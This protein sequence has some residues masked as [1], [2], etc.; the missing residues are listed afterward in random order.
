MSTGIEFEEDKSSY[1]GQPRVASP[2]GMGGGSVPTGNE[3]GIVGWL[4][5]SGL[6]KSAN[7]AQGILVGVLIVVLVLIFIVLRYF[8]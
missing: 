7:A 2:S 6:A 3:R 1:G 5:R 8:S 4:I